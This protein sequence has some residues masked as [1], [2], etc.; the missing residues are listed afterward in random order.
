MTNRKMLLPAALLVG[1]L[2][3]AGCPQP[4]PVVQ[5]VKETVIVT[6][7]EEVEVEVEVVVTPTPLPPVQGGVW[8]EGSSADASILNPILAADSC[9]FRHSRLV[10]PRSL[11]AGPVQRGNCAH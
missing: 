9:Q 4:T 2:I 8:V 1:A 5:T 6:Q 3:L 7:T 11:G 10:L